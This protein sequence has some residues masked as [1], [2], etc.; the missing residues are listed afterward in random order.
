MRVDLGGKRYLIDWEHARFEPRA[1]QLPS[2]KEK[3]VHG[4]TTCLIQ[5]AAEP[6]EAEVDPSVT[7]IFGIAW[8]SASDVFQKERGRKESLTDAL[9]EWGLTRLERARVWAEYH[10]RG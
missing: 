8:C 1:L 10:A 5:N 9:Q 3:L 6:A 4:S 7:M 2:G